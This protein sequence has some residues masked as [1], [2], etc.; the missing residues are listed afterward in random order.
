MY[1]VY[2]VVLVVSLCSFIMVDLFYCQM[3]AI[4][5]KDTFALFML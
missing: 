5:T 2:I 4:L 1:V 3:V